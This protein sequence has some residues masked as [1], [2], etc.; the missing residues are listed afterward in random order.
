M[1]DGSFLHISTSAWIAIATIAYAAGTFG[2]VWATIRTSNRAT[3]SAYKGT[4]KQIIAAA[5]NVNRQ[6]QA[7]SDGAARQSTAAKEA[8]VIQARASSI[9]NNRQ[10]WINLLRDEITGF[11]T[12]IDTRSIMWNGEQIWTR[13]D[14]QALSAS[15]RR[16]IYEVELLINPTEGE[17][18]E[19]LNMM[20]EALKNDLPEAGE[21]AIITH[22]QKILKTEWERVKRGE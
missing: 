20:K 12:D 16:H 21:N 13:E 10:Q 5:S 1:T 22:T 11:L 9:S 17:S 4:I 15:L 19:L 7:T 8:A 3:K 6:I 14:K 18:K 2:L